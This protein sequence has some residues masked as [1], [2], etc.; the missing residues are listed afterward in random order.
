MLH[1]VKTDGGGDQDSFSSHNLTAG[2]ADLNTSVG[3]GT[4]NS[5]VVGGSLE[6]SSSTTEVRPVEERM[7]EYFFA[8]DARCEIN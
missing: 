7:V 5:L 4:P 8:S 1:S 6:R 2:S 3:F